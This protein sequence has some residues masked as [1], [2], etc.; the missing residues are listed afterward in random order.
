[1]SASSARR[2]CVEKVRSW[3]TVYWL[4]SDAQNVRKRHEGTLGVLA[5]WE[6]R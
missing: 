6:V 1:M 5:G 2:R 4:N 3:Q